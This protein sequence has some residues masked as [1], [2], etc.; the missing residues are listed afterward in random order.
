MPAHLRAAHGPGWALVGDAGYY[1]DAMTAHGISN[2]LR[3]A[4]LLAR[5]LVEHGD[6]R[7]YEE[8]RDRLAAPVLE[9]SAG[10]AAYEWDLTEAQQ[11]H[12]R[13]KAAMDDDLALLTGLDAVP[14]AV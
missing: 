11:L 8:T 14:A 7:V 6:A 1:A 13:L 2:A 5:S 3:D 10:L 12:R 9:A 4:E